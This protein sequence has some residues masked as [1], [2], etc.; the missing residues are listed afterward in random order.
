M[1]HDLQ[2]GVIDKFEDVT[3]AAQDCYEARR[4]LETPRSLSVSA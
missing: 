4:L 3:G 2:E 1:T